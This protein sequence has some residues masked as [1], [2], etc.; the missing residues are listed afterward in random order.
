MRV[1]DQV[2]Y[3]QRLFEA[4]CGEHEAYQI[5]CKLSPDLLSTSTLLKFVEWIEESAIKVGDLPEHV[6]IFGTGGDCSNDV[7]GK[8]LNISSLAATIASH[9]LTV[10]KVGTRGITAKWGS[11]DFFKYMKSVDIAKAFPFILKPPSKFIALSDLGFKYTNN[12]VSAR[13]RI[14]QENRL[15]IFKVIF[16]FANLTRSYGQVNGISRLEYIHIF[17]SLAI[18]RP[19]SKILLVHNAQKHDEILSGYNKLIFHHEKETRIVELNIN[20]IP[21]EIENQLHEKNT[22]DEQFFAANKLIENSET[23]DIFLDILCLNAST[24]LSLDYW[25]DFSR[26][27]IFDLAR[28]LKREFVEYY[29][30]REIS[31]LY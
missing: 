17:S 23:K 19:N 12:I 27:L 14:F 9:S 11:E 1:K 22:M 26:E 3:I 8:T 31:C 24:I 30:S 13:K 2:F 21:R 15:D 16:P 29:E 5:F 20:S 7:F 4:D 28:K 25:S 10:I 6:N 18:S